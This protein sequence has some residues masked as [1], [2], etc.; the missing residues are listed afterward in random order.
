MLYYLTGMSTE[1]SAVLAYNKLHAGMV[2]LGETAIAETAIA[3]IRRQEPPHYAFY[4]LSAVDLAGRLF[5]WQA[6]LTRRIRR[7]TWG[8]VGA[9]NA[10]QKA[11]F[12]GVLHRPSVCATG[13]SGFGEDLSRV[14]RDLS[15]GSATAAS[16]R[17][18][19]SWTRCTRRSPCTTR[20]APPSGAQRQGHR[21]AGQTPDGTSS[22]ATSSASSRSRVASRLVGDDDAG[23]RR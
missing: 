13:S 14:E 19:T 5:L 3:P 16:R 10:D 23:C 21:P 11:D 18:C 7:L 15:R 4:K 1:R 17:R 2:E 12:G 20:A 22:S 8:P 9:N 6:W